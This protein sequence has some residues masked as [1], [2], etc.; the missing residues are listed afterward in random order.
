MA[1]SNFPCRKDALI[2]HLGQLASEEPNAVA[3]E[4][5]ANKV[6]RNDLLRNALRVAALVHE[7]S[8]NSSVVP[9]LAERGPALVWAILGVWF[10]DKGVAV[11]DSSEPES[12][13]N[14]KLSLIGATDVLRVHPLSVETEP[15]LGKV[16]PISRGDLSDVDY[17][18]F[19]SGT[20]AE[21]KGVIG[22][23][24]P[25]LRFLQWYE[26]ELVVVPNDK[27][28]F[29]SGLGHDPMFRDILLPLLAGIPLVIPSTATRADPS[30][31]ARWMHE[32]SPTIVHMVP[33]LG[34]V[35]LESMVDGSAPL[36]RVIA[37]GGEA[38]TYRLCN[39]WQ[40]IAPHSRI[41]N[42]YGT[43][44]TPQGVLAYAPSMLDAQQTGVVPLGK[45]IPG[46]EAGI[47][48]DCPK[49]PSC[50]GLIYIRSQ[51]LALGYLKLLPD[52]TSIRSPLDTYET[53]TGPVF[54][55]GDLGY[56]DDQKNLNYVGRSDETLNVAGHRFHLSEVT[57]ALRLVVDSGEV[58]AVKS[59]SGHPTAIFSRSNPGY[60]RREELVAAL[61]AHLTN[62]M[63][64]E[65]FRFCE[66][67]WPFTAN[68]KLDSLALLRLTQ[69]VWKLST[70][71]L[72]KNS[73]AAELVI[74]SFKKALGCDIEWDDNLIQ[75][76]LTSLDAVRAAGLIRTSLEFEASAADILSDPSPSSVVG[77]LQH[78]H[79]QDQP[80]LFVPLEE[81]NDDDLSRIARQ[82]PRIQRLL[83]M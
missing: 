24:S 71:T 45:G 23:I 21:P 29:I 55:T 77:L 1:R 18:N 48:S 81:L 6:S 63:M 78:R 16:R 25:V 31:L 44:E 79:G 10:A 68:G 80:G 57:R 53:E 54:L 2:E 17:V 65:D 14:L 33:S 12:R 5:C 20:T 66:D 27:V 69:P 72:Y 22:S 4:F 56:I 59:L 35:L 30:L 8:K 43:T 7:T 76:G 58:V 46:V 50:D 83:E 26:E 47:I 36:L 51:Q 82:Y 60:S 67:P 32:A 40:R 38:L 41:I 62:E 13:R 19:T 74:A 49:I 52:G 39:R 75:C 28:S 73:I 3:L 70:E 37:F 15:L 11:I 61:R 42:F 9:I 64:P 34:R